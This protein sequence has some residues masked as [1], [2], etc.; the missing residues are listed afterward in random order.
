MKAHRYFTILKAIGILATLLLTGCQPTQQ[1]ATQQQASNAPAVVSPAPSTEKMF[2][3]FEGPWAFAPD[4]K[5]AASVVAIAPRS[6][7][8]RP[9]FVKASNE[10][11][12]T[13][14]V[15]VLSFPPHSGSAAGSADPSI[16]QA[17]ID[18]QKLQQALDSKSARYVIHLPKPEEYRVAARATSRVGDT[19]PPTGEPDDHA[20][21]VSLRYNVSSLSGF[22]LSGTPDT[23]TFDTRLLRVETPAVRFVIEPAKD[24]DLHDK[25]DIHSRAS[26]L[27][28]TKLLGLTLFVDFPNYDDAC[29]KTDPQNPHPGKAVAGNSSFIEN[30]ATVVAGR[31]G[32][33]TRP[34]SSGIRDYLATII[35][36]FSAPQV[37]CHGLDIILTPTP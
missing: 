20:S 25:C 21:A 30:L 8:H 4:P 12:L 9:L 29:H 23:S 15:Y 22:S 14:G 16:V 28:L 34:R 19:Y 24:D 27:S 32:N 1:Q 11:T 5:D 6:K 2:I 37:D 17:K 18:A 35:Y 13:P 7:I 33:I 10:S 26:F 3:L 36:F 31:F